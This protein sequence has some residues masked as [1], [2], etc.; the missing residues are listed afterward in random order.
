MFTLVLVFVFGTTKLFVTVAV[1]VVVM[2][3]RPL[4]PAP[5]RRAFKAAISAS[6]AALSLLSPQELIPMRAAARIAGT[7]YFAITGNPPLRCDR[8]KS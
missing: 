7:K 1:V 4:T 8:S 2:V 5:A 6:F 3:A